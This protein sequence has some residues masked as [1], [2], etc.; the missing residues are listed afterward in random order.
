[1]STGLTFG[2]ISS[3][4]GLHAGIIDQGQYSILV[5][6]V[7]ASAV[8]PT[9]IAQRWFAP[10]HSEDMVEINGENGVSK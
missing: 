8:L 3:V 6:V 5:G 10:V 9:F 1:M 4:Y 7:V 2:T